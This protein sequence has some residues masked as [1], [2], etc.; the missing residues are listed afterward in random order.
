[1]QEIYIIT[2]K[3][4]DPDAPCSWV[5]Q[6]FAT[7][8]LAEQQV[9][10]LNGVAVREG[11]FRSRAALR[12]DRTAS[13]LSRAAQALRFHGDANPLLGVTG[14]LYLYARL[15]LLEALPLLEAAPHP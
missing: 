1:M 3:N 7:E 2:G 5:V 15:S 8:E 13:E 14:V 4:G 6:A 12:L 9:N 10:R 11:V